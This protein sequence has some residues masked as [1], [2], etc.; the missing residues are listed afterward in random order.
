MRFD[1]PLI[2]ESQYHKIKDDL[3]SHK[4]GIRIANLTDAA[5]A[6]IVSAISEDID[7]WHLIITGDDI[8]C[9]EIARD[10]SCFSDDIY[11]YQAKCVLI[12]AI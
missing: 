9:E 12:K 5:K 8:R 7:R 3:S 4:K 2:K 1:N 6:H 11:I 10:L